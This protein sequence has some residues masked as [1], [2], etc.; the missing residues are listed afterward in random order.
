M[1]YSLDRP[2]GEEGEDLTLLDVL[3]KKGTEDVERDIVEE[4][5]HKELSMKERELLLNTGSV[6]TVKNQ[7]H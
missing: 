3:S 4:S 2:I 5:L 1:P 7:K 6:S